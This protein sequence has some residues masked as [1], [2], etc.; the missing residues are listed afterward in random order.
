MGRYDSPDGTHQRSRTLMCCMYL[1]DFIQV[2]LGTVITDEELCVVFLSLILEWI[3]SQKSRLESLLYCLYIEKSYC[4]IDKVIIF[5][6]IKIALIFFRSK[7]IALIKI[8]LI[9]RICGK[10]SKL[11]I[12]TINYASKSGKHESEALHEDT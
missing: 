10:N 1:W 8:A 4:G 3:V 11:L 6:N 9:K 12:S 7:K 2:G 5:E